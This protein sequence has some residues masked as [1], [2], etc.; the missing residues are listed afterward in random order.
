MLVLPFCMRNWAA[1][2]FFCW[3]PLRPVWSPSFFCCLREN[4]LIIFELQ[5]VIQMNSVQSDILLLSKPVDG[6]QFFQDLCVVSLSSSAVIDS[7][8]VVVDF[9]S[10]CCPYF[11]VDFLQW[12]VLPFRNFRGTWIYVNM[13]KLIINNI[14]NGVFSWC[15][16]FRN[17]AIPF[18]HL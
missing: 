3:A 10:F 7:D 9:F 4:N 11:R 18:L 14:Q 2:A 17:I 5:F 8:D 13:Q 12:F 1:D 15:Y 16:K 6:C